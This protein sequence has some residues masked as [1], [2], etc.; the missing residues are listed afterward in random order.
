MSLEGRNYYITTIL[1]RQRGA[2]SLFD[3]YSLMSLGLAL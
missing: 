1:T 3:K 2:A